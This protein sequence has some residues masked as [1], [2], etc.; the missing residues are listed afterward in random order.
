MSLS[1]RLK[2]VRESLG[3]TQKEM[4]KAN[5]TN[6]QTSQV[7]EAGKSVPGGNVLEALA[8]MGFN[9][10]WILT[11]DGPIRLS[12]GEKNRLLFEEAHDILRESIK[13]GLTSGGWNMYTTVLSHE[14]IRSYI[15][16]KEYMPTTEELLE[17]CRLSNIDVYCEHRNIDYKDYLSTITNKEFGRSIEYKQPSTDI[18]PKLMSLV[19]EVIEEISSESPSLTNSQKS[20]LFTFVYQMNKGTKFTKDRL[21][22]FIEAVCSFIEQGIDFN[23][24]SDRKLNNIMVEIA[25]HVVRGG[26]D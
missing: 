9:V 24:L 23:R 21:K 15:F 5:S 10:N 20:E 17:L 8:R 6:P 26:D 2:R 14:Q 19:Y 4:A 25:H 1:D 13:G 18:D 12:E 16:D 3:Y 22:R 11:G 7:Y